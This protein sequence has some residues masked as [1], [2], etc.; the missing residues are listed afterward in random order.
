MSE[1]LNYSGLTKYDEQ[2]KAYINAVSG[3]SNGVK[4]VQLDSTPT[5]NTLTYEINGTRYNFKKGDEAIVADNTKGTENTNYF[6]VYKLYDIDANNIAYW[7]LSGSGGGDIDKITEK[8]VI[9][10]TSADYSSELNGASVTVTIDGT[11]SNYVWNGNPIEVNIL[12]G[13]AYSVSVGNKTGFTK[14]AD[15]QVS[16]AVMGFQRNINMTYTYSEVQV[17]VG[18][19]QSNLADLVSGNATLTMAENS[20]V[21]TN[22]ESNSQVFK[23]HVAVGDSVSFTFTDV[24]GYKTPTIATATASNDLTYSVNYETTVVNVTSVVDSAGGKSSNDVTFTVNG[25]S[26][27]SGSSIKIATGNTITVSAT[28]LSAFGYGVSI[29]PASG[30]IASGTNMTFTAT[31]AYG[32]VFTAQILSNQ[33]NDISLS[34]ESVTVSYDSVNETLT[35][36]QTLVIP[37]GKSVTCVFS[38]VNTDYKKPSNLVF[39]TV[40]GTN[41]DCTGKI[42]QTEILT[43]S[44]MTTD[45]GSVTG[46]TVTVNGVTKTYGTDT[47]SWKIPFDAS[48][49]VTTSKTGFNVTITKNPNTD[50]ADSV[51]KDLVI[52]FA[53]VKNGVYAI[54]NQGV[55]VAYANIDSSNQSQYVGVVVRDTDNDIE[56][57]I[58]KRFPTGSSASA[59][60]GNYKAWA[61]SNYNVDISGITNIS[62]SI[63]NG[64]GDYWSSSQISQ[65]RTLHK[66]GETGIANTDKIIAQYTSDTASNNAAKYCRSITNPITGEKNGY[67]GSA[68]EWIAV[69]E[70]LTAINNTLNAI[71]GVQFSYSMSGNSTNTG[72]WTSTEYD[73]NYAWHWYWY[74][75]NSHPYFYY[76]NKNNS[77]QNYCARTFFPVK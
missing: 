6:V 71:G 57:F 38:N 39:T 20:F 31:Y 46:Q 55:E 67:L 10:L 22:S 44:S 26:V 64:N 50:V 54:T 18:T 15:F 66:N 68:A 13:T 41:F 37:P 45:A 76:N 70:N 61:T 36:G 60:T 32:S 62:G 51:S 58:D 24:N 48:D 75:G 53:E 3:S 9:T 49:A 5:S 7:A 65:A 59:T 27:A 34:G 29:S 69:H 52:A 17:T 16:S 72:C 21:V 8:A 14:P 23:T 28:D 40:A 43:L 63:G 33:S 12:Q 4:V 25:T 77:N 42:Y 11:P 73:S 56:F 47:M 35:N 2:I 30:T 74:S 1:Y 19:N